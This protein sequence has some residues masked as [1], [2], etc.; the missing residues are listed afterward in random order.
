[1]CEDLHQSVIPCVVWKTSTPTRREECTF[2]RTSQYWGRNEERERER[3]CHVSFILF[4]SFSRTNSGLYMYDL[5]ICSNFNFLHDSQWITFPT[6]SNL[7]LYS[8]VW[9]AH[10]LCNWG[11]RL[12]HHITYICYSVANYQFLL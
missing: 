4:V 2:L 11:F 8:L 10:L 3:L 12:Y 1:M 5:D 6:Q 9:Y 7:A